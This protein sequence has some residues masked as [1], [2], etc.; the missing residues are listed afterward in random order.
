MKGS[1]HVNRRIATNRQVSRKLAA[2][3]GILVSGSAVSSIGDWVYLVA[4]NLFVADT[5]HSAAAVATLWLIP[6]VASLLVG[7]FAGSITDRV[8]QRITMLLMDLARAV[9]IALIPFAPSVYIIYVA[10][11][12]EKVAGIFFSRAS[13]AYVTKLVP[14]SQRMR[15]NGVMGSLNS[16]ALLAGPA[17]AGALMWIGSVHT[18]IWADSVSFLVS[19]I[20]LTLLPNLRNTAVHRAGELDGKAI[21]L[22]SPSVELDRQATKWTRR[23]WVVLRQDWHVSVAFLRGHRLFAMV[24]VFYAISGILGNAA[25]SVEVVFAQN[26]LHLGKI[27]YSVM[28]FVAGIG[29][30]IGMLGVTWLGKRLP[31]RMAIAIGNFVTNLTYLLYALSV[32]LETASLALIPLGIANAMSNVGVQTYIQRTLPADKMGRIFN[33]FEPAQSIIS[34]ACIAAMGWTSGLFGVRLMMEI[35]TTLGTLLALWGGLRM[36]APTLRHHFDPP[37]TDAHEGGIL[38]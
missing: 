25:N 37:V 31:V 5:T 6:Y 8:N 22:A 24:F 18:A 15:V 10:I 21:E 1:D 14:D 27:G 16:G 19:A 32:N 12:F 2:Q 20:S 29:L 28:V 7:A 30:V 33:V 3:I 38:S 17:I 35:V 4:L 9:I 26:A 34:M 23:Y 13:M 36:L 11:L